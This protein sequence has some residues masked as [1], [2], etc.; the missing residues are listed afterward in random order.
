MFWEIYSIDDLI[1]TYGKTYGML[2]CVQEAQTCNPK[3]STPVRH[4]PGN[5]PGQNKKTLVCDTEN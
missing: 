1:N 5:H 2:T 4:S 3:P